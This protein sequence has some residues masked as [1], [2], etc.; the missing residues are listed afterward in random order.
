MLDDIGI[1]QKID[2][3]YFNKIYQWFNKN[4]Y[5]KGSIYPSKDVVQM[6]TNEELNSDYFIKYLD[7]KFSKI[8][9]F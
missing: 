2:Q 6:I 8:Y 3:S 1:S 4:L 9:N 7:D 5:S